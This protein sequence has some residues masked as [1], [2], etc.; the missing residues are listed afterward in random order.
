MLKLGTK[1]LD[2]RYTVVDLVGK[3]AFGEL[4]IV[5]KAVTKE[6]FALKAERPIKDQKKIM[7]FWEGKIL[8]QLK[9]K[10][11]VPNV[12]FVGQERDANGKVFHVL[13]MDLLGKNLYELFEEHQCKF[14]L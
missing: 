8:K 3:G 7:L 14:D 9:D 2:T 12:H 1:I 6:R 5:E 4:Y 11:S 13:I 10:T